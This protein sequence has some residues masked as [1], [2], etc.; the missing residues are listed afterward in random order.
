MKP[1]PLQKCRL[2]YQPKIPTLLAD[3][4]H[5][6]LLEAP[7]KVLAVSNDIAVLFPNTK[8]QKPLVAV[9]GEA[10]KGAPLRVG[11]VF[12]GG[13]ASGGHNVITGIFDALAKRCSGSTLYGFL[14]GPRGILEG[15]FVELTGPV[16]APYRNQGG[17]DL[18][19]SGRTKIEKPKEFAVAA[20]RVQEMALDGFPGECAT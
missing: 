17:F 20:Q 15:K 19:G 9:R 8:D 5:V 16:L 11:V 1:S 14:D 12:S 13:Q 7:S 10:T 6:D 18:L 4:S 3:I 2:E